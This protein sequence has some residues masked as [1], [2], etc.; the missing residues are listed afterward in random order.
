M[1]LADDGALDRECALART[2]GF[3]GKIAVH[4]RQVA[5]IQAG[6]SPTAEEIERAQALVDAFREAEAN[7]RGAFRFRGM[8]VD[9]A[10]L[11]RAEQLLSLSGR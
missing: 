1:N 9:Y 2:F 6:F 10:N 5:A 3:N 4:P 8:M 11:R 7:G